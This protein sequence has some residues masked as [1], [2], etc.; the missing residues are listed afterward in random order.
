MLSNLQILDVR[1]WGSK[2]PS[3]IS[4]APVEKTTGVTDG[5]TVVV[6][7][8]DPSAPTSLLFTVSSS[9]NFRCA[10]GTGGLA[11]S[12]TESNIPGSTTMHYSVDFDKSV[13]NDA[14]VFT[15]ALANPVSPTQPV[16]T[17][18]FAKSKSDRRDID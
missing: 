11:I 10:I 9:K 5:I 16:G 3:T 4:P 14:W 2:N 6:N 13:E 15:L 18:V 8:Y 7:G 12:I 17:F 1:Q